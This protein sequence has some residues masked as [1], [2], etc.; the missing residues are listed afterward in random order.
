MAAG[1]IAITETREKVVDF[2]VPFMYYTDDLLVKKT[3]TETTD[4]LQFMDPF[5]NGVWIA[6]LGVVALISIAVFV[7]NYFSPYGYKDENGRGTSEEF[8]FFNSMWFSLACMLQQGGDNT[9][10]NLSGNVST[11]IHTAMITTHKVN[12]RYNAFFHWFCVRRRSQYN[13]VFSSLYRTFLRFLWSRMKT[14]V[15]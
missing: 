6:T 10:R 8:N 1:S 7:L 12:Y 11:D 9:P 15:G 14:M 2:T 4:L 5:E 13:A 3:S